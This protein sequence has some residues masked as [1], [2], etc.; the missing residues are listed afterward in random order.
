M[1]ELSITDLYTIHIIATN[2]LK[3]DGLYDFDYWKSIQNK[4]WEQIKER[5]QQYYES[6]DKQ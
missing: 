4:S 6:I 3:S 1:K 2:T 5:T